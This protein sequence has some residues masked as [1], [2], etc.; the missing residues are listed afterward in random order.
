[1]LNIFKKAANTILA[2]GRT[3][4]PY[5]EELDELREDRFFVTAKNGTALSSSTATLPSINRL[6]MS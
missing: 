4:F 1:M 5:F 2:N 3:V 6:M